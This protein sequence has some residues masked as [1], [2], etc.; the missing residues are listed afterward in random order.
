MDVTRDRFS[1]S[2][3]RAAEERRTGV[4]LYITTGHPSL[5]AT[6]ELVPALVEA[7][8]D[9]I[10]L[11]VPFSDPLADGA[12]IQAASF[13][14]LKQGV[15]L[16]ACLRLVADLRPQVPNTPMALMGYYNPVL[17]YGLAEFAQAGGQAGLDGVIVPDLPPEESG[18]LA[19]ECAPRR[20]A[21][22][23]L[24]APTSTDARIEKAC[25]NAR[26][27]IYCVSVAGVTGAREAVAPEVFTLLERVRRYTSL[28][29]AVGFGISRRQHV[30]AI[31]PRAEAVVVGSALVRAIQEAPEGRMVEQVSRFVTGLTGRVQ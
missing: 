3:A 24:V 22:I 31:G 27:F 8:A 28:P 16:E 20:I 18:L 17:R 29:R 10:E 2:F 9:A 5:A 7:G 13:H 25:K 15:T 4:I 14:A 21:V 26:G 1:A 23:P 11:G 19:G 6:R 30:E 12:T